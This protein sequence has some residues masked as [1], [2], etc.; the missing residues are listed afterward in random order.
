MRYLQQGF[1][2]VEML[3]VIGVLGI[4]SAALLMTLDPVSQIQKSRDA[5]RKEDLTEMQRALEIFYQD[6]GWYPVT[7]TSQQG[8]PNQ[9]YDGGCIDWG[10]AWGDAKYMSKLPKE[11][12]TNRTYIYY[13]SGTQPQSYYLYASLERGGKDAQACNTSG[14]ACG[15]AAAHGLTCGTNNEVCNFGVSSS[16]T[17][18]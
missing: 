11:V 17:T 16:N 5:K 1:T 15:N 18:P 12:I 10:E 6:H 4:L 2:L 14:T 13:S 8:C 9:I 3:I 7:G